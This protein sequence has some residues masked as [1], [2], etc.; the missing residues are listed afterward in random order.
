MLPGRAVER[1]TAGN[2]GKSRTRSALRLRR[3]RVGCPLGPLPNAASIGCPRARSARGRVRREFLWGH[4]N[5][6]D[7]LPLQAHPFEELPH[8]RRLA[9]DARQS[10]DAL[11]GFVHRARGLAGELLADK[12]TMGGQI[13]HRAADAPLPQ[14]IA[15]PLP[16]GSDL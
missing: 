15:T 16:A 9:A 12:I 8:L 1:T 4:R 3:T 6:A 5:G 13:A 11:A 14:A 7:T 2:T 10:L